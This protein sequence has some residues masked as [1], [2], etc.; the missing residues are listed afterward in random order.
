MGSEV[1]YKTDKEIGSTS[2]ENKIIYPFA[3]GGLTKKD[4]HFILFPVKR[5]IKE[6]AIKKAFRDDYGIASSN[7]YIGELSKKGNHFYIALPEGEK[8]S[9]LPEKNV[10]K[11]QLSMKNFTVTDLAILR[12]EKELNRI[13]AE[14]IR[15][16]FEKA[17]ENKDENM[18]NILKQVKLDVSQ[19]IPLARRGE[20]SEADN[21]VAKVRSQ[22]NALLTSGSVVDWTEFESNWESLKGECISAIDTFDE[23]VV[24]LQEA[25]R[26]LENPGFKQIANDG[27]AAI[28]EE[29]FKF[30]VVM[31]LR[32]VDDNFGDLEARHG[33]VRELQQA[34]HGYREHL[35]SN[36]I[37]KRIRA[38]E[39]FSKEMLDTDMSFSDTLGEVLGRLDTSLSNYA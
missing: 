1:I 2:L 14:E 26:A 25:F 13:L 39:A 7:V 33:A 37:A 8:L 21:F 12:K 22:L 15:P 10:L 27:L 11:K 20:F 24:K 16:L 32:K 19:I 31:G 30:P 28:R 3:I 4:C 17:K 5:D 6:A 35:N 23:Q 9:I 34:V 29:K 36:V 38:S 18:I